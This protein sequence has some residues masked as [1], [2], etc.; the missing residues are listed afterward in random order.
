MKQR[1]VKKIKK[2]KEENK[3]T[4]LNIKWKHLILPWLYKKRGKVNRQVDL[5]MKTLNWVD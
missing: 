3:N 2:L 5:W 1:T 4:R